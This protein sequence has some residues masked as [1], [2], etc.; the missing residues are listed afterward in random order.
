[1]VR[2]GCP[3]NS[4]P[5]NH[6][7]GGAGFAGLTEARRAASSSCA[8]A[9]AAAA[10][11][12]MIAGGALAEASSAFS[13]EEVMLEWYVVLWSRCDVVKGKEVSCTVGVIKRGT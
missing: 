11:A 10:S 7:G 3:R 4:E 1:M 6:D 13:F 8:E 9:A 5:Q 2:L 12:T